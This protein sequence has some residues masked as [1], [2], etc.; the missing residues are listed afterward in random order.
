MP[1]RT[2]SISGLLIALVLFLGA[3][4]LS[5]QLLT[6]QRLDLTASKLY[7]LSD[8]SRRILKQL[9]EPITLRFYYSARQFAV[10][11]EFQNYGKRVRDLLQ[12]YVAAAD[13]RL[14][15]LVIEPE[16]FSD[17]EDQAVGYGVQQLPINANGE[18]GY[19]GLVGSNT[20]GDE[21]TLPLL[22]P[23]QADALEYE[24]TK[25]VYRLA[26]PK[27]RLVGVISDLPIEGG[28]PTGQPNGRSTPA[29]L[30]VAQLKELFDLKTLPRETAAIDPEIDTLLLVHPKDLPQQTLYA[31]DQFVL[32]GGKALIFVDPLAEEDRPE[33]DPRNPMVM[34]KTDSNLEPLFAAW[35]IRMAPDKVVGDPDAAVRVNFS[36]ERGPQEVDYLPWL[37]LRQDRLNKDDFITNHLSGINVGS[38]GY[39]EATKDAKTKLTPLLR[40]GAG[41]GLID[42]DSIVIVRDPNGLRENFKPGN[43]PY[44]L[45]A[46]VSGPANSAFPNGAPA[47]GS[48]GADGSASPE[49]A[50]PT[51]T[52]AQHL[53][54]A[55]NG[56]NVIVVADTD[57]LTDRFWV[58]MERFLGSQMPNPFANNADFLVNAVDNL[59]GNDDLISLRSRGEYSRPFE[60]VEQIKRNAEGQFREREKE[61]QAKLKETEEKLR[62]L[63][64]RPDAGSSENMLSPEQRKEI[65]L[66]RKEQVKTRKE[67][68][69]VQHELG[70]NI[71][72]LG[73]VVKAIN[74]G[75]IPLLV[76]VFAVGATL[77][78]Q[79]RRA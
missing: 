61:L 52:A 70:R 59:G 60:V 11:P 4:S 24:V 38:A 39:L 73:T 64:K 31:I 49:P 45:A 67:L 27:K 57:I 62:E 10:V 75:L 55:R 2:Q 66:F 8:G 6:S 65:D 16:P 58:R 74:I 37:Q 21:E 48:K 36:S 25:L 18:T 53:A 15:L 56:I 46:R 41:S 5:N 29:W 12:E 34:P 50:A 42:R 7:T 63:R 69:T 33:P 19:L 1:N 13:G 79:R 78:R 68:R 77:V 72:Q 22:H 28:A 40:S 54:S 44:V 14:K 71:E 26:H 51:A 43:G 32:R 47:A 17:A 9:D 76:A 23:E 30:S 3:N 35:G 20:V